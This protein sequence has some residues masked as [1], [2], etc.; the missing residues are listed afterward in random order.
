MLESVSAPYRAVQ[1]VNSLAVCH[2]GYVWLCVFRCL[3][4]CWRIPLNGCHL[5]LA[6]AQ[7]NKHRNLLK[8][9]G[10]KIDQHMP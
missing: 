9:P 2:I 10:F 3:I 5:S 4:V 6:V 8:L 7:D 1:A